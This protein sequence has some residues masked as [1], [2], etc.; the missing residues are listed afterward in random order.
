MYTIYSEQLIYTRLATLRST[1]YYVP[2]VIH[3][4]KKNAQIRFE[5]SLTPIQKKLQRH[6]NFHFFGE[7][8]PSLWSS[9]SII[10]MAILKITYLCIFLIAVSSSSRALAF[11]GSQCLNSHPP[12]NRISSLGKSYASSKSLP[13]IHT[14]DYAGHYHA[15][16]H[17]L[18]QTEAAT[19]E[20]NFVSRIIS[21]QLS[22]LFQFDKSKAASMG[23]AFAMTYNFISNINGSITLSTAWYIASVRVSYDVV[24]H[25]HVPVKVAN[26]H[27]VSFCITD[28]TFSTG[29]RSM[30][31]THGCLW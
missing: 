24:W 19:R 31:V 16:I 22:N 29:W 3:A 11:T 18:V 27:L 14:K 17:N 5:K 30:E 20:T 4:K 15:P 13:I 6:F 10:E 7:K 9:Y 21:S 2:G 26:H 1:E 28:W 23:V 8:H 12:M 25:N